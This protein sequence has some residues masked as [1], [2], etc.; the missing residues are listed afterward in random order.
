MQTNTCTRTCLSCGASI[1]GRSDKK[2]C[3]DYCRNHYNNEQKAKSAHS[4]YVRNITNTLLRNR[5]ILEMLLPQ[6]EDTMKATQDKLMRAGFNFR[7]H[8]HIY[9][10]KTGKT[11][12]YCYEYGYLPLENDWLLLV[13]KR[14]ES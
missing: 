13:R 9:I 6:E 14:E 7:Y 1:R 10:T 12:T 5:R 4:P 8:T 3:D 11:Y 2:F